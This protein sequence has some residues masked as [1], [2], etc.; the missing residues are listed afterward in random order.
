[1]TAVVRALNLVPRIGGDRAA[2]ARAPH[3]PGDGGLHGVPSLRGVRIYQ[4]QPMEPPGGVRGD[5]AGVVQAH[6]V[7]AYRGSRR[8]HWRKSLTR[9]H[10]SYGKYGTE[11]FVDEESDG[12]A[13]DASQDDLNLVG[14]LVD[15]DAIDAQAAEQ[16]RIDAEMLERLEKSQWDGL[17]ELEDI[18]EVRGY[19]PRAISAYFWR[20]PGQLARRTAEVVKAIATIG[21][22]LNSKKYEDLVPTIEKL[23]PTYVKFGQALASRADLVGE[24]LAAEL[25]RLQDEM[26]PAPIELARAIV[27]EECPKALPVLASDRLSPRRPSRR[28]TAARSTASRSRS[29]CRGPASRRA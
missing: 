12:S 27:R 29:R 15:Q 23:G 3:T 26:E 4:R 9:P 7:G 20:H 6:R 14:A 1:M 19:D 8:R 18:I 24:E 21:A 16:E 25:E 5:G 10:A 17:E 2:G 11:I 22:L 28:C 13:A